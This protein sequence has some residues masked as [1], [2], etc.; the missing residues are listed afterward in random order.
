MSKIFQAF[1]T[2]FFFT[3][4][5]DFLIILGLKLNYMDYH[6]LFIYYNEFFAD[7]QNIYIFWIVT[8]LLGYIIIY[9]NN[10]KLSAIVVTTLLIISILPFFQPIGNKLGSMLFMHKNVSYS[11]AKYTYTGDLQYHARES[12][13]FYDYDLDKTILLDTTTLKDFNK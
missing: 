9:L 1:L 6:N 8:L 5:F 7:N 13:F 11:D 12:I 10:N 3:S 2:G 4:I